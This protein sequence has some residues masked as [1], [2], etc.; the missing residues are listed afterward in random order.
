M[1][2]LLSHEQTIELLKKVKQGDEGAKNQLVVS[3]MGLVKSIVAKFTGRGIEYEDLLQI[4]SLGLVRAIMNFDFKFDVK[5][6]TYA[7][8]MIMGEIKRFL[9]DDGAVKVSR[10]L[11]ES[12]MEIYAANEKLKEKLLRDPTINELAEETG[13]TPEEVVSATE[14]MLKPVSLNEIIH[15]DSKTQFID[16]LY[17]SDKD[18]ALDN[19][20][21]K[22][23]LKKL[24]K[25]EREIL[26]MR[27]SLDKTQNEI[28]NML[29]ISQVQV[30][31][32]IT[33]IIEKLKRVAQE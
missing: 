6:S 5:F 29:G 32:L 26:M 13:K 8:P 28:A 30:S 15:D 19:I 33:R 7:V 23:L 12:A 1:Y 31:R 21:L 14:A 18:E 10:S 11:K 3:N 24:N 17:E 22:E 20:M 27:F 25:K 2:T 16:L 9:R 4:G